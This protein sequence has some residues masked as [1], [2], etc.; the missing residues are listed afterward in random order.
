MDEVDF[1]LSAV[2]LDHARKGLQVK[3]G[4]S[5]ALEIAE[6][7][8]NNRSVFAAYSSLVGNGE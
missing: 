4:A 3:L 1:A 7:L 5:A 2:F 8:N 6:D